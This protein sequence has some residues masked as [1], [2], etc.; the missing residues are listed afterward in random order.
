ML[1]SL[2]PSMG[3]REAEESRP[4]FMLRRKHQ[5]RAGDIGGGGAAVI[6]LYSSIIHVVI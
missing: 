2:T 4:D 5:V 6:S 1:Y 3:E